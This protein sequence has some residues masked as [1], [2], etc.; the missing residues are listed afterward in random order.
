M[1]PNFRFL[2]IPEKWAIA[3]KPS[4]LG[5]FTEPRSSMDGSGRTPR[6]S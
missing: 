3:V 5:V 2:K 6:L 4:R 1:F